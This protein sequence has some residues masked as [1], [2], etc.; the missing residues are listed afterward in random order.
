MFKAAKKLI[1]LLSVIFIGS[2]VMADLDPVYAGC[3]STYGGGEECVFNKN[4][5]V[6]KKVRF[7]VEDDDDARDKIIDVEKGEVIVFEIEIKNTGE[8]DVDDMSMEDFL[9]DELKFLDSEGLTE[10]WDDFEPGDKKKFEIRVKVKDSEYDRDDDF[11]K[12]VVN[13]VEIEYDG[14]FEGSDTATV[15]Y[16]DAEITE[17]PETGA[18]TGVTLVIAGIGLVVVGI[19]VRKRLYASL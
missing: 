7:E 12:C 19:L 6:R 9:P 18:G 3:E 16:G 2:F 4:F 8:V 1:V 13:K 14:D 15:C 11:E 5:R 17:L 10:E